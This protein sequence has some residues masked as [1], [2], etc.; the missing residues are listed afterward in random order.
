[1]TERFL[2]T[3]AARSIISFCRAFMMDA[4][5]SNYDTYGYLYRNESR[6]AAAVV[7]GIIP[8]ASFSSRKLLSQTRSGGMLGIAGRRT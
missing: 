2:G 4:S 6:E 7:K 5:R 3:Y 1:M 8:S